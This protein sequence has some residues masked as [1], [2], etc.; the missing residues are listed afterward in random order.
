[1]SLHDEVPLSDSE[2]SQRVKNDAV[3]PR[4]SLPN[5]LSDRKIVGQ[6]NRSEMHRS[7]LQRPEASHDPIT[8]PTA[9][10]TQQNA[11]TDKLSMLPKHTEN[12]TGYQKQCYYSYCYLCMYYST[13]DN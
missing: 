9:I 7:L 12:T 1:M 8:P 3:F 4:L 6:V 13:I 10:I 5:N 2:T 11:L